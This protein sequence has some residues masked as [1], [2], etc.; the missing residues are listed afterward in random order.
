MLWAIMAPTSIAPL[1]REIETDPDVVLIRARLA[2]PGRRL[3]KTEV[4]VLPLTTDLAAALGAARGAGHLV[5]GLEAVAERLANEA[6]GLARRPGGEGGARVSRLLLV[7]E[8][9]AERHYRGVE[10]LAVEHAP[11]LLVLM[12]AADAS[13]LGRAVTGRETPVK[14]ALAC[15]KQA[16]ATLLRVACLSRRT[17]GSVRS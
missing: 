7:S 8:D 2:G 9:G 14:A 10:R 16:A 12:L 1:P 17:P 5:L 15:H 6:H 3:W 4:P 13:A 11:R